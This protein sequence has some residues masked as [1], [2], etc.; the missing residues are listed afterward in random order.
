MATPLT[1]LEQRIVV[2]KD[3]FNV[4]SKIVSRQ[5]ELVKSILSKEIEETDDVRQALEMNETVIDSLEVKIR[6]EVMNAI[7]LYAPRASDSRRMFA[8]IDITGYLERVGDLF[9]NIASHTHSVN[10]SSEICKV[11]IPRLVAMLANAIK[12]ISDSIIAFTVLDPNLSREIIRNDSI[13]DAEYAKLMDEIPTLIDRETSP[14]VIRTAIALS[15]ISY[16]IE[17]IGD[18]ATNIAEAAIYNAEGFDVKH[19]PNKTKN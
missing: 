12:M 2:I 8:Y 14:A 9:H 10:Y 3:N 6:S 16:N 17:R 1:N 18:N 7:V 15:S 11:V 4:L 19:L 5:G 13:I